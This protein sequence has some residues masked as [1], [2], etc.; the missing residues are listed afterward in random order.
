MWH[1]ADWTGNMGSDSLTLF[2]LFSLARYISLTA[3]AG[4]DVMNYKT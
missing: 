1:K 2:C 4:L 3:S